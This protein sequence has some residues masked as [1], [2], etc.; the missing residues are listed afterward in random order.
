MFF[1]FFFFF[2]FFF[3]ILYT[4][5]ISQIFNEKKKKWKNEL[6]RNVSYQIA[7]DSIEVSDQQS[8][9]SLLKAL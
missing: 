7:Y 8:D 9:Q 2:L 3:T 6:G 1:F 5:N 4:V